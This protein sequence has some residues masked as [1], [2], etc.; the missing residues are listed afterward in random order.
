MVFLYFDDILPIIITCFIFSVLSIMHKR[1][2]PDKYSSYLQFKEEKNVRRTIQNT[3][4]R[5]MYIILSTCILNICFGFSQ[6]QI[7]I[8]VFMVSFLNIWPA[9]VQR[10][11]LRLDNQKY[12]W[13]ILFGYIIFLGTSLI[14][15][16]CTTNWF[17]PLLYENIDIYWLDNN[18]LTFL[19][20]LFLIIFPISLEVIISQIGS[21][22]IIQTIDTFKEDLYILGHQLSMKNSRIE[23]NKYNIDHY[24]RENDINSKLL[25]AILRLEIFYRGNSHT[26]L[27][28]KLLCGYF[29]KAAIKRDISVGIGQIKISTAQKVLN[30][31]SYQIIGTLCNDETNIKICAMYIKQ[32]ITEFEY[33]NNVKLFFSENLF[34]DEYNNDIFDYIACEYIGEESHHRSQTSLIYSSVLRTFMK[35]EC[36]CYVGSNCNEKCLITIYKSEDMII[37]YEELKNFID[38]IDSNISLQKKV[39]IDGKE[40]ELKF[41][42]SN[43]IVTEKSRRFA[44]ENNCE[45]LVDNVKSVS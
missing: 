37:K 27:L 41:I 14:M 40:L 12:K 26:K 17:I 39:F 32:L 13:T 8:G 20:S 9:V 28:E 38:E 2:I 23:R 25:E 1:L 7:I 33:I 44:V 31:D 18:A 21:V 43:M 30:L 11:L 10:H 16:L 35:N 42:S 19:F 36:L 22:T 34:C 24:A 4:I 5:M 3:V 29:R 6:R 45:I 15:T